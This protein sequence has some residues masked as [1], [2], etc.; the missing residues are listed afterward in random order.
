[1]K[2]ALGGNN[3][4]ITGYANANLV[5]YGLF[6]LSLSSYVVFIGCGPAEWGTKKQVLST[7]AEFVAANKPTP[8]NN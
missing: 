8:D 1:M 6:R 5:A 4:T 7:V 3:N 2:L